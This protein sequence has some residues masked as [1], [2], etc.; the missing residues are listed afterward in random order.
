MSHNACYGMPMEFLD[1]V[2]VEDSK[3]MQ[4]LLRSMLAGLQVRRIR[5]FDSARVALT[6]MLRDPPTLI[7]TDLRMPGMSGLSLLRAIRSPKLDPLCFVPVIVVTAHATR[8]I[9]EE[10]AEAGA[11]LVLVKPVAPAA[12]ADRITWIV[13]DARRFVRGQ[14]GDYVI[15]G[16]PRRIQARRDRVRALE[17]TAGT[18]P[19][20]RAPP[21]EDGL[22]TRP[23]SAAGASVASVGR[24]PA[25]VGGAASAQG[26]APA[27]E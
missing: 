12:L 1:I 24:R 14:D 23:R 22:V 17:L 6:A 15:E 3:P 11:H 27:K 20:M 10:A 25:P 16:V 13:A 18:H 7:I 26:R 9:V 19:A 21:E 4:M 8:N 5:I 2:V